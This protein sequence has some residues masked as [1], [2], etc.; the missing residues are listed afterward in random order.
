MAL[1]LTQKTENPKPYTGV[2][3]IFGVK[4]PKNWRLNL[5]L[6][7]EPE[8]QKLLKAWRKET[9]AEKKEQLRQ[10]LIEYKD[11]VRKEHNLPE[12]GQS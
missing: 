7:K 9:D 8:F 4:P 6:Q 10:K 1:D 3:I 11:K 5:I 12:E 2:R